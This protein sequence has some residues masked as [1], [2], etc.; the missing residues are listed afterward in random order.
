MASVVLLRGVNV[1]GHRTFSPRALADQLHA[2]DVVNVGAAGTF[3]VRAPIAQADLRAELL[4]RLPFETEVMICRGSDILRLV[5]SAPLAA[6]A[7]SKD[8]VPF[9]S[10]LAARRTPAEGL[11]LSF[12]ATGPWEL[13]I[14]GQQGR[15]AYGVYRRDMRAVRNLSSLDKVFGCPVT[16]RNWNTML[17]IA[18]ILE[19]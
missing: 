10:V 6:E 15:F 14:V 19:G 2:L 12:P 17:S 3:V 18:R 8:V 4:A 7:T 9:V 11:P 1:G 5:A 16:T 13:R